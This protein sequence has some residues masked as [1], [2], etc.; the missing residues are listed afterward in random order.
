MTKSKKSKKRPSSKSIPKGVPSRKISATLIDFAKPILEHID[1][2]TTRE[3]VKKGL[4]VAITVWNAIVIDAWGKS[5][6]WLEKVRSLILDMGEPRAT[7][8]FEVLVARKKKCF[9]GDLR[10]ITDFSV[11]LKDGYLH[12]HAEARM[13]VTVLDA[14]K[15]DRLRFLPVSR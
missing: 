7:H 8:M 4:I 9:A 12:V 5:E 15:N 14:L 3:Q 13:D 1:E 2:N 11:D 6:G 10:A